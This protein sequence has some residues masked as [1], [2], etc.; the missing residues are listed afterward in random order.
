M[1]RD[2]LYR[3]IIE[4]LALPL[5]GNVFEDCAV[6]LIGKA[7][8]N[9]APMRGG[10]DAGMDGTFGTPGGP[11]PLIC[12]VQED[13]IGNFRDNISTYR[14]KC[15]GPRRASIATSQF[16]SI[17]K[18]RNLDEE[19]QELGVVIR[20]IYDANAEQ[21]PDPDPPWPGEVDGSRPIRIY[22]RT[23]AGRRSRG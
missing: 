1:K 4:A 18:K 8:P 11:F 12:T 17:A 20:N 10:D 5:D 23:P 13:V 19:A 16:L 7:H 6:A 2:P 14:R 22:R 9:L 3:K 21:S 15:N